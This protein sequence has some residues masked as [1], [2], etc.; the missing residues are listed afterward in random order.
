MARLG[1]AAERR[2]VLRIMWTR[3]MAWEA[4]SVSGGIYGGSRDTG[5][6]YVRVPRAR[7]RSRR[8]IAS[9]LVRTRRRGLRRRALRRESERPR[10]E[11]DDAETR[12]CA[13]GAA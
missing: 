12:G 9:R 1:Y 10:R 3:P 4:P 11:A 5:V 6:A 13:E 8:L 2:R 7:P